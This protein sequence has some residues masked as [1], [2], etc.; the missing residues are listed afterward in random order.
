MTNPDDDPDRQYAEST[1][2]QHGLT[3][4]LIYDTTNDAAWVKSTRSRR[5]SESR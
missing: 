4:L 3:W 2:H 1:I 5:L